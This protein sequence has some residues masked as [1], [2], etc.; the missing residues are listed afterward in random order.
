MNDFRT[1]KNNT[2]PWTHSWAFLFVLVVIL[3][4]FARSAYESFAKKR[5]ADR[6]RI[7]YEER[8]NELVQ[9]KKDL[10][11][12]INNLKTDRGVEEE[13]RKRFNIV[14]PGETLIR[15]IE[16]PQSD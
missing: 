14:K 15:I 13:L 2:K 3:G 9:K 12:R 5:N 11:N 10:E 7:K 16:D 4:F 8:F 6:E 1:R